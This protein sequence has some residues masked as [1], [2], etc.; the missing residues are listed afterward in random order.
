LMIKALSKGY[1]QGERGSRG[2]KFFVR[3]GRWLQ[4]GVLT[5]YWLRGRAPTSESS[6]CSSIFWTSSHLGFILASSAIEK[7]SLCLGVSLLLL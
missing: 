3:V 6:Y 4:G 5:K 2:S 1:K 7:E